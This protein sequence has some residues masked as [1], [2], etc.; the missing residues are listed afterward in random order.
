MNSGAL[1]FLALDEGVPPEKRA[2]Y[3]G[4]VERAVN[5][6]SGDFMEVGR[7]PTLRRGGKKSDVILYRLAGEGAG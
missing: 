2:G 7:F 6:N 1:Q 3:Y 4:L 5:E